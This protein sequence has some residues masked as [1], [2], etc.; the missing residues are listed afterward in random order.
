MSEHASRDAIVED[1]RTAF[2]SLESSGRGWIDAV[3][4][5]VTARVT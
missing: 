1:I 4:W 5:L 2:R 3:A